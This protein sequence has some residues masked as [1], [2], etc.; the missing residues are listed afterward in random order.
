[1]K[2]ITLENKFKTVVTLCDIGA[3]IYNIKIVG[4]SGMSESIL[5]TPIKKNEFIYSNSYFGK[6]IGRTGGRI[7][8][9]KFE[10]NGETYKIKSSDPNGLH[11][12]DDSLAMMEFEYFE[13]ETRDY[14]EITFH[15]LSKDL[16]SGYPG[17]LDLNVIYKLYKN[18][19]K[20]EVNYKGKTDKDTLLNLS[21][22]AYFN[23]NSEMGNDILRHNLYINAS[24]MEKIENLLPVG[25]V[26]C[27]EIYSF[28]NS[29]EI[30]KYLFNDEIIKNTNGYDYPYIFDNPGLGN[31]N[32]ILKDNASGRVMKI[33]TSYPVCVVYTCNYC[34][35]VEV[36]SNRKLRPYDAVCLEC[37]YHPNTINSSFITDKK[38][39]LKKNSEYNEKIIYKFGLIG[40]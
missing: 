25:I 36:V 28:K 1:M 13:N 33:E 39:V 37:M 6:T 30:G 14:Y 38:D 19:N 18:E 9:S 3:S 8:N 10:L 17:N 27:D 4:Q 22:H 7:S 23:L 20:L 12:G 16:E 11:G 29:H 34:E 35:D 15:Y 21:N 31:D 26:D 2:F 32:I 5:V 40:E 24:K